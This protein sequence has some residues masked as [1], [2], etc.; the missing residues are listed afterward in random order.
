MSQ[1][2]RNLI[3]NVAGRAW[4]TLSVY[5]FVPFYL[6]YLGIE[7]YGIVALYAVLLNLVAVADLGIKGTLSREMARLSVDR[8]DSVAMRDLVRTV[9]ILFLGLSLVISAAF[10]VVAPALTLGWVNAQDIDP[11]TVTLAFRLMG[12]SIAWCFLSQVHQAGLVGLQRHVL[13]NNLLIALGV[14]RG[15]GSILVLAT[16]SATVTAFC[17]FQVL[18]NAAQAVLLAV[19]LW[20]S[21]PVA[22]GP[23]RFR[24]GLLRE[25]WRYTLGMALISVDAA[26]L[27]QLDKLVVSKCL[28]LATLGLYSLGSMVAQAPILLVAPISTAILPWFTQ[29]V[30]MGETRRLQLAYHKFC[31]LASAMSIPVAM[32]L[33]MFSREVILIWTRDPVV[34]GQ[35]GQFTA[36]LLIGSLWLSLLVIPFCLAL[37]YGW[38]GLNVAV[39]IAAVV[40]FAPL[41]VLLAGSFGLTG[42]AMAWPGLHPA[43]GLVYMPLLHRRTLPGE[44]LPSCWG[45]TLLPLVSTA[46][47]VALGRWSMP[48]GLSPSGLLLWLGAVGILALLAA[49]LSASELRRDLLQRCRHAIGAA[50]AKNDVKA[51]IDTTRSGDFPA[52]QEIHN[53]HGCRG[54]GAP[55][56][57]CRGDAEPQW[58]R[59]FRDPRNPGDSECEVRA[60]CSGQQ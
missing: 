19:A 43:T 55:A 38:T 15:F 3:A 54:A 27:T 24:L 40:L 57:H 30:E 47:V 53:A 59:R 37:A 22:D 5:L 7:A 9:E 8:G 45:D 32:V 1:L 13:L 60:D 23:P 6:A 28:P 4:S 35:A 12:L 39:G 2:K 25:T 16:I 26:L 52:F 36:I 46:V 21:L 18:V 17:A 49:C 56:V 20:R 44:L 11:E 51:D 41:T 31:Q 10:V 48:E 14:V 50:R 33:G 29:L 34:A 58:I 42:V